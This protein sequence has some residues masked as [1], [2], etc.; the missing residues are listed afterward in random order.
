MT[1]VLALSTFVMSLLVM[2]ETCEAAAKAAAAVANQGR[3]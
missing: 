2:L 3:G 1:D